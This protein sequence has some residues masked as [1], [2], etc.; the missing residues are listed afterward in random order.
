[1]ILF[2]GDGGAIRAEVNGLL[3]ATGE[4]LHA[5]I[6]LAAVGLEVKRENAEA[7]VG[8][9]GGGHGESDQERRKDQG[10]DGAL[11]RPRRVQRRIVFGRRAWNPL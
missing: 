6:G 1:V 9:E 4:E 11:R 5:L 8:G 3:A 7:G 10:R 2:Q